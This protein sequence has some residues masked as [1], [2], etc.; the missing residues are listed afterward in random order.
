[1]AKFERSKPRINE[2]IA[3][4]G[5]RWVVPPKLSF[6]VSVEF[7]DKIF[8]QIKDD[9][10]L[11]EEM[12]GAIDK[13]YEQTCASIKSKIAAFE[14]LA[15]LMIDKNAPKAELDKQ[16]AGVNRS[17]EQD[18]KI[19]EIA[20][21]QAVT[22][23]WKK[24]SAKK[25]DYLKYRIK[26]VAT[27]VGSAAGLATS[28]GLMASAPFT[29]GASAALGIIAMLKSAIT[30]GKELASAWMEVEAAQ[31]VLKKQLGLAEAAAQ[32]VG[33]RKVNEYTAIIVSQFLGIAQPCMKNCVSQLDTVE[34]KLAGIEIRTHDA[35]KALNG[36]LDKQEKLRD[37]FLKEAKARLAKHPSTKAM[38]QLRTIE[39]RLD[40]LM[41]ESTL[42]VAAQ[43]EK[44]SELYK[45][46]QAA[47][48]T[49]ESLRPR[50]E[51]L[52][53]MRGLDAVI[54]ENVL[55]LVDLPI[56]ALSGNAPMTVAKDLAIGI[57]PIAGLMAYD[58][59]RGK[60]LD[61]TFLA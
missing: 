38:E 46:F 8:K 24:Y 6:K 16:L 52:A 7:D 1:M 18:R 60:V 49:T 29:G 41:T 20:C 37:E 15:Q 26:I 12:G 54:L 28:I 32:N 35:S 42:L 19:A 14:K 10:I 2:D 45:R 48:I 31:V 44:T 57:G 55:I 50:V 21:E 17:I 23:E 51:K 56:A 27:V 61:G 34:K 25:K 59:I 30:I 22:A 43:I 3:V 5:A 39:Q 4:S 47:R 13:V 53:K 11:L 9:A 33:T 40:E 36:L 58:K